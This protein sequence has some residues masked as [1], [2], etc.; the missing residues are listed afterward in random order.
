MAR[1]GL[2]ASHIALRIVPRIAL[3]IVLRA[4]QTRVFTE[5]LERAHREHRL[6]RCFYRLENTVPDG[7]LTDL[8]ASA[9]QS[10]QEFVITEVTQL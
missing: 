2:V 7:A 9:V 1:F 4:A 6:R 3:S 10:L 8:L 5:K